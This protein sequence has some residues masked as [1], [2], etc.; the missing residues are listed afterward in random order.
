M[1]KIATVLASV[2][3]LSIAFAPVDA[4]AA[5]RGGFVGG[6]HG[7][8][9]GWHGGWGGWRGG[10]WGGWRGGGWGWHGAGWGLGAGVG[11]TA[12]GVG[13]AG[14]Y[15]DVYAGYPAVGYP[16]GPYVGDCIAWKQVPGPWGWTWTRIWICD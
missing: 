2:A 13:I 4:S 8:Y 1:R 11:V 6:W 5:W 12:I 10:G 15:P 14:A 3:V 16:V 7:G 9:G